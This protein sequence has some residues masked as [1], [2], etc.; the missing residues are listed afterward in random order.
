MKVTI[1]SDGQLP[2]KETMPA[3]NIPGCVYFKSFKDSVLEFCSKMG[4]GPPIYSMKSEKLGMSK[5]SDTTLFLTEYCLSNKCSS[6][7]E[8]IRHIS[9]RYRLLV[10]LL[11]SYFCEGPSITCL[12]I[13]VFLCFQIIL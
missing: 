7:L 10:G 2:P 12:Y 9:V 4:C 3:I 5:A 8:K 13:D 6:M 11:C 1:E